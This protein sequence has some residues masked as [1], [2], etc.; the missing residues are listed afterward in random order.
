M[1]EKNF[2]NGLFIT[3]RN[4]KYGS[5]FSLGVARDTF[6]K[7]LQELEINEKG[8]CNLTITSKKEADKYGTHTC[9]E[10]TYWKQKKETQNN[11]VS[12]EE[13]PND[14]SLPF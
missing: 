4:T 8:Y 2:A 3:E 10:D 11:T 7:W 12:Y 5:L 9:F 6:V 14:T 1:S 13:D